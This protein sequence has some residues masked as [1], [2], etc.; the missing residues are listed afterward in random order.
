MSEYYVLNTNRDEHGGHMDGCIVWWRAGGHGYTYDLNDAGIF[1]EADMEKDYPSPSGCTYVPWN[2]NP[3][4]ALKNAI[5]RV[6][7]I[8]QGKRGRKRGIGW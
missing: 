5:T 4:D 1:T 3:S 6:I 8:T 2:L 7:A